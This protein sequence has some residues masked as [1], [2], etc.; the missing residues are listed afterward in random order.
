[1]T[2]KLLWQDQFDKDGYLN[3][4]IWTIETGGNGFGN[5]EAQFYTNQEKNIYV[6][7]QMLHIV[8]HKEDYEHRHYTSGKLSTYQKKHIKYGRIEVEAKLP[9]GSGTW[10]AIWLLGEN[11]KEV[12]WPMCGEIDLI[13]HIGRRPGQFH[14]SLHTQTFNH[15]KNNHLTYVYDDL[16]LLDD[17]QTYSMEWDEGQI[18][19]YI[20]QKLMATFKKSK[21]A[22]Q[23]DWPYDQPFHLI[24][25]LA[26]GG[27]WGGAIDESIFPVEFKIKSIKVYERSES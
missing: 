16:S 8:A 17:F 5:N 7:D 24:I 14:F 23:E 3:S 12:G 2:Y 13:E 26:I 4:D 10:P 22:T 20:N 6:K 18:S 25:N 19:F 9:K 11:K 21:H 27:H 15:K 1:M